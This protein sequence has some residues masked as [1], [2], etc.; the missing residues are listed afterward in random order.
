MAAITTSSPFGRFTPVALFS[1]RRLRA[2]AVTGLLGSLLLGIAPATA[3]AAPTLTASGLTA[4]VRGYQVTASTTIR[5]SVTTSVELFGV[6]VRGNAKANVDFVKAQN[7]RTT[8][9]GVTHT[10]KQ[11]L[12]AGTYSYWTCA[13][14]DGV[15]LTLDR[16]RPF[17][18]TAPD[19]TVVTTHDVTMP[20]GDLPGWKQVFTDDFTT[21][22]AAGTFGGVYK[23]K[24]STY[25]G[26]ADSFKGGTYNRNI[27]SVANGELDMHLHTVQRPAAGRR[28]RP[29]RDHALGRPDL[30]QV[31][32]P[33]QV[34][35]AARLQDRLAAVAGHRQLERR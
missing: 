10:A 4:T 23:N 27:L 9:A 5:S 32:G 24:F 28:T 30:R 16:A 21:N 12:P 14:D 29:H 6:C 25:H 13:Y 26:F 8:T 20:K 17:V 3:A 2:A 1:A 19:P 35:R 7:V 18:V 15:W 11:T 22:A 34:R 33:L 31:L